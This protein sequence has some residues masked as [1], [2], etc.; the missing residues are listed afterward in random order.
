MSNWLYAFW[1]QEFFIVRLLKQVESVEK[2]FDICVCGVQIWTCCGHH[3]EVRGQ[4]PVEVPTPQH[5]GERP[6]VSLLCKP[7]WLLYSIWAL[8]VYTLYLPG[9]AL[10]FQSELPCLLLYVL[11]FELRSS[12]LHSKLFTR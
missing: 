2:T 9:A 12:R 7:G 10:A 3:A 1:G 8:P 11:G 5:V 4:P 6:I